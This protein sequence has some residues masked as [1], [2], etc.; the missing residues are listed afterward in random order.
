VA[1]D[2]DERLRAHAQKYGWKCISLR[3]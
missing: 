3:D 1:V 2:A